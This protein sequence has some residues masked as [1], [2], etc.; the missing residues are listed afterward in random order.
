MRLAKM[1]VGIVLAAFAALGSGAALANNQVIVGDTTWS[2]TNTCVVEIGQN[3]TVTV[4]DCCGGIAVPLPR[5][6][7]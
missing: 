2:C 4:T 6:P 1:S 5:I 3:G 7:K